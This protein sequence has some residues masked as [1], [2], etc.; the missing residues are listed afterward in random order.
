METLCVCVFFNMTETC[1][2]SPCSL[3]WSQS[4]CLVPSQQLPFWTRCFQMTGFGNLLV[5]ACNYWLDI[6]FQIAKSTLH[7]IYLRLNSLILPPKLDLLPASLIWT[8]ASPSIHLDKPRTQNPFLIPPFL[9]FQ[10]QFI[11]SFQLLNI[12]Q[13]HLLLSIS[14]VSTC[15]KSPL[16]L[17]WTIIIA[18]WLVSL[19]S[20]L[21]L[22]LTKE[23][24][25][26][27]QIV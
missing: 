12:L 5:W 16:F 27:F 21:I 7:S 18:S 2:G 23:A 11:S 19:C 17:S 1:W 24:H 8:I 9:A 20:F 14:N 3:L 10:M 26:V 4:S 6:S 22:L 25:S 13:I 15:V